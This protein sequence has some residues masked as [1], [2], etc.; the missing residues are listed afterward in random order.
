MVAWSTL[1]DELGLLI[2]DFV[3]RARHEAA[4]RIQASFRLYR[5]RVLM[6]RY[7]MLRYLKDFREWNP[8]LRHF[9]M[10]SRL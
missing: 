5:T 9:L 2:L 3:L 8:S 7:S 6:G 10:H 4:V 1:P